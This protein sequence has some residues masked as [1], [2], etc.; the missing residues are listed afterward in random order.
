MSLDKQTLPCPPNLGDNNGDLVLKP[1]H[2]SQPNASDVWRRVAEK[3]R[4]WAANYEPHSDGMNTFVL[5]AE[6]AEK[7]GSNGS[8][9]KPQSDEGKEDW[10][11]ARAWFKHR[12]NGDS[13]KWT[14][15]EV[16]FL[17]GMFN[18][19]RALSRQAP[20]PTSGAVEAAPIDEQLARLKANGGYT[21]MLTE[22]VGAFGLDFEWVLFYLD[23]VGQRNLIP[24]T[25]KGICW[26]VTGVKGLAALHTQPPAADGK[27]RKLA[28]GFIEEMD[29][30]IYELRCVPV[31]TDMPMTL[32]QQCMKIEEIE[33]RKKRWQEALAQPASGG[34]E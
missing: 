1:R 33:R 23:D 7:E 27:L 22:R 17:A 28:R 26:N 21:I 11:A 12:F 20:V 8:Q 19:H 10:D 15:G 24:L 16:A 5:F 18:E 13:T 25:N 34:G 14:L 6:W 29:C 30:A 3:A 31:G 9:P 2:A 32:T 4:D